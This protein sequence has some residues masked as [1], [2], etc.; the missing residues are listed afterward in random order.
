MR[1]AAELAYLIAPNR[2]SNEFD[3]TT[4]WAPA[5]VAAGAGAGAAA[6]GA[7]VSET[8]GFSAGEAGFAAV[9]CLAGSACFGAAAVVRA[10]GGDGAGL[11]SAFGLAAG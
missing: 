10:I 11:L 6:A 9:D 1:R 5:M 2:L 4:G 8:D 3:G 7:G